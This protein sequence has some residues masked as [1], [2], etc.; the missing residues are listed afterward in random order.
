MRDYI[1]YAICIASF[2]IAGYFVNVAGRFIKAKLQTEKVKA[3][4]EGKE[5]A[6]IAFDTASKIVDMVAHTTV[7]S[8]EQTKAKDLR[9]L[10]KDGKIDRNELTAVAD[11]AYSMIVESV[12]DDVIATLE[13]GVSDID[14]YIRNLIEKNVI[15]M[16]NNSAVGLM[17]EDLEEIG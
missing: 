11:E 2:T 14:T 8:L 3:E 17:V 13:Q 15:E 4:A 5:G 6:A 9:N 7:L 12:K 1:L 16:K 10:V